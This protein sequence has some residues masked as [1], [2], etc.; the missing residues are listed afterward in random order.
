MDGIAVAV[1]FLPMAFSLP[2]TL[3]NTS[4]SLLTSREVFQNQKSNLGITMYI[5]PGCQG[6][7][8]YDGNVVNDHMNILAFSAASYRLTRNLFP[9]EQ[10][11]FSTDAVYSLPITKEKR[12]LPGEMVPFQCTQFSETATVGRKGQACADIADGLATVS[13]AFD[14]RH[15]S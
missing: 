6:L 2:T 10:L 14:S 3:N 8:Y 12:Q 7:S 4:S 11:D 15:D 9:H 13:L 1:I 5:N